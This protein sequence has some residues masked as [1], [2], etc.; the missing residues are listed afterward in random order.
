MRIL[1]VDDEPSIRKTLRLALEGSLPGC[2]ALEAPDRESA[3]RYGAESNPDLILLDLRLG[4][5]NGLDLIPEL[6]RLRPQTPIVI[7]TAYASIETAVDAVKR[8]ACDYLP[9]PFTPDQLLLVVEKNL[10]LSRL[11]RSAVLAGSDPASPA[12]PA[13]SEAMGKTLALLGRLAPVETPVLFLGESGSGKTVL[14]R[15][16]HRL[17]PRAGGPFVA[18]SCPSIP[19]ELLESELFGHVR[20]A[21]TGALRDQAGKVDLAQGGTLFLDEIGDLPLSLQ[22]KLLR[23]LQEKEYERVGQ[24]SPIK[25]DVRILA[26]TNHDLLSRARAGTFREDLYYRLAVV[27]VTVP[28]LRERRADLESLAL[29]FLADFAREHRRPALRLESGVLAALAAYDWPG[30]V[31]ELRNV[32][33][34]AVLL[35]EGERVL[36]EHLPDSFSENLPVASAPGPDSLEALEAAQIRKVLSTGVTLEKAAELLGIHPATLWRKRRRFGL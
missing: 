18:V 11:E 21:F 30:N 9:K 35:C 4:T 29:A 26:A 7:M 3:L 34:R 25:A 5:T 27:P 36:L 10:R 17:G 13:A 12:V 28:P 14:A 15:H 24:P 31:R 16:L 23:F 33:E 19:T 1:I 8:G 6:A 32:L 20:G 22:P 2:Q